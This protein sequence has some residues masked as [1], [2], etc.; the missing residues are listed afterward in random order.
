MIEEKGAC[1]LGVQRVVRRDRVCD[2]HDPVCVLE[3][4]ERRLAH[5][6]VG[7]QASDHHGV[8]LETG[9]LFLSSPVENALYVCLVMTGSPPRGA[10]DAGGEAPRVPLAQRVRPAVTWCAF[11]PRPSGSVM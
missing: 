3:R 6:G 11:K 8:R 4:I 7:V 10:R 2:D 1:D 5:A 9:E